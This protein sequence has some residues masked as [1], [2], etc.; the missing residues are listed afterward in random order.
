MLRSHPTTNNNKHAHLFPFTPDE[1]L[2][3]RLSALKRE[4]ESLAREEER[5]ALDRMRHI[6]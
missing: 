2:Q 1:R 4:E 5:L 3:V 6:R